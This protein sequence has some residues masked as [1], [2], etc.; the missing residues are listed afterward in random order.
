MPEFRCA[1]CEATFELSQEVVDRYPGWKPRFCRKH[2][3]GAGGA[4]RGGSGGR[5]RSFGGGSSREE[6][7]QLQEV[8]DRY[9]G[10]PQTGVFTDGGCTPNPGPGGWGVVHVREGL[11]IAQEHGRS[12][13]T[14]NNRMELKALIE[15]LKLLPEDADIAVYS[16]SQLCV[17]T[18][19]EWARGWEMRG[20]KRKAGPIKN[21][22]L[23]QELYALAQARPKVKLTWIAAHSGNL[24][25]EYADSLASAWSRREL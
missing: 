1:V 25:N 20:W 7:L 17:R 24:W 14:T 21:L 19:N 23:V 9:H 11:I 15:A 6:N 2:K 10:G 16:D 13:S 5:A 12:D 4:K 22:E 18:I 8:L 3:G